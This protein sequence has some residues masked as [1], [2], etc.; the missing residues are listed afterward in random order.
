MPLFSQASVSRVICEAAVRFAWLM[1]PDISSAKRLMR[2]A[3]ALHVS[4]EERFK[5]VRA[6]S[7]KRFDPRAYQQMLDSSS[8]QRDSI[9]KLIDDTGMAFGS[10]KKGGAKVGSTCSRP[11]SRY[12]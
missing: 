3:V 8:Q 7:A 12:L 5:G 10:L 11:R 9:R 1:D 2:G 6:L 4:A